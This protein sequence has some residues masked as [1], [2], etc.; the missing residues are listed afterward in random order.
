MSRSEA[1]TRKQLIDA[2]ACQGHG[3]MSNIASKLWEDRDAV[4]AEFLGKR[5]RTTQSSWRLSI[6]RLC[7]AG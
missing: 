6:L 5:G 4:P 3:W 1:E 7:F 2:T